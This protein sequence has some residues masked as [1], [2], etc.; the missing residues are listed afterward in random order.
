MREII[1]TG[2][3]YDQLLKNHFEYFYK[4]IK[5]YKINFFFNSF[6]IYDRI[7]NLFYFTIV[8]DKNESK[9][10]WLTLA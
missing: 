9:C 3:V 1:S 10:N 7:I 8:N 4:I 6:N 5:N 2:T